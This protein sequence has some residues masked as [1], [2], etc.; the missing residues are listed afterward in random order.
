MTDQRDIRE[1][2]RKA[3]TDLYSGN[4][5]LSIEYTTRTMSEKQNT[6]KDLPE[7]LSS[8]FKFRGVQ[9]TSSS[10]STYKKK[11]VVYETDDGS[12]LSPVCLISAESDEEPIAP[13]PTRKPKQSTK[14][15]KPAV[16]LQSESSR[17]MKTVPKLE[18]KPIV[19]PVPE[20]HADLETSGEMDE[21]FEE[22]PSNL[23]SRATTPN[24]TRAL[25]AVVVTK[26]SPLSGET[27]KVSKE[28]EEMEEFASSGEESEDLEAKNLMKDIFS[29]MDQYGG[30]KV[31]FLKSHTGFKGR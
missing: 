12:Y 17:E 22:V 27:S 5:D 11:P 25:P 28:T 9:S 20:P 15:T 19:V 13:I 29:L 8:S 14:E 7:D 2:E 6:M 1:S 24:N 31:Q 4:M 26:A 30:E 21:S 23:P 3:A 16:K 18:S 10:T